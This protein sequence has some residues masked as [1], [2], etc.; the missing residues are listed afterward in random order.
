MKKLSIFLFLVFCQLF[1]A[2]NFE[3]STL[4]IGDFKIFM[5]KTEA[6]KIAKKGLQTFEDYEK[7][8]KVSLNGENVDVTLM[9]QWIDDNKPMQKQIYALKTKSSKFKTKSGMG[10]GNTRDQLIETYRNYTNFEV[11]QYKDENSKTD[12]KSFFT[13]KDYDAGTYLTFVME[14]NIVVEIMVGMNEGC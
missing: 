1:F 11:H 7:T 12:I 2:Q 9:D 10:V 5:P 14:N 8:N 13:L 4:R 3:I 6:D